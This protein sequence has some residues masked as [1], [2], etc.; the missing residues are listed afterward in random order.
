MAAKRID[1]M[2]IRQLLQLK[3]KGWSNRKSAK[4]IGLHRNSV[5]H[6]VRLFRASGQSYTSLLLH[7]DQ[8]L[9][10]L[11]P[12]PSTMDKKKYEELSSYRKWK[13]SSSSR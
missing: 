2:D 6:Y 7:S 13:T 8:V 10:E 9:L 3:N 12:M 5:N 1:I 4:T 11:F